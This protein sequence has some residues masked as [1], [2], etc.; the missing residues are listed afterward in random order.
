MLLT[1]WLPRK[2]ILDT[3]Q[4]AAL[5][6]VLRAWLRFAVTQRDISPYRIAP[7]VDAVDTY[8]A[9]FHD[10]FDDETAWSPA[11]KSPQP[12]PSE[13]STSRPARHRPTQRRT[14]RPAITDKTRHPEHGR[15]TGLDDSSP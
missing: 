11:N 5:P 9:V 8:L 4:R 7:V 15:S 12:S 10:A 6:D 13:A 14:T 1:D 2:A 3:D